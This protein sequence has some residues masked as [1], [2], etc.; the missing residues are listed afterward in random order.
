MSKMAKLETDNVF[1][2]ARQCISDVIAN[3]EP[4][5]SF[6]TLCKGRHGLQL[7]FC[8]GNI[9]RQWEYRHR[10]YCKT[11]IYNSLLGINPWETL[12][13]GKLFLHI[14]F[15]FFPSN[16]S[17]T[18]L[19]LLKT[20]Q[21]NRHLIKWLQRERLLARKKRCPVCQNRMELKKST[22]KDGY[23]W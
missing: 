9:H 19:M 17:L 1:L 13:G 10:Q 8:N 5:K 7:Y 3:Y 15:C 12:M 14:Y 21:G 22:T 20:S 2:P 16:M 11:N 6:N 23:R 18:R 4:I